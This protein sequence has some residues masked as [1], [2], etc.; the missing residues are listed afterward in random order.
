MSIWMYIERTREIGILKALGAF[1]S[2]IRRIFVAKGM[3]I[4]I[5]GGLFGILGSIAVGKGAN[6]IVTTVMKKSNLD[7]FQFSFIQVVLL[8]IFSGLL[9]ILASFVPA[10]KAAKQ[11][12]V[13]ALR[14]E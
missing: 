8:V 14:Y 2:D 12:A 13:E 1:R 3:L 6:Y 4:G 11:P 5:I 9:G 10:N 7:I